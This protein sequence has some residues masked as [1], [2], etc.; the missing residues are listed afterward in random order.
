MRTATM[1]THIKAKSSVLDDMG[2]DRMWLI[3]F[4]GLHP[5]ITNDAGNIGRAVP[6]IGFE[7]GVQLLQGII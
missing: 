5:F 6:V 4:M 2:R 3:V 1:A 7:I